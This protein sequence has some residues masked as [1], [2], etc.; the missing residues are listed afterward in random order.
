MNSAG[1]GLARSLL[2][3]ERES[4]VRAG[5]ALRSNADSSKTRLPLPAGRKPG[6]LG[7][8]RA[9]FRNLTFGECLSAHLK[10]CMTER[11]PS[12][13]KTLDDVAS[14]AERRSFVTAAKRLGELRM[15]QER[16]MDMEEKTLFPIIERLGGATEALAEG[17]AEHAAIRRLL[18][19]VSDALS[20]RAL[21]QFMDAHR[22][23][24][25][26]LS[27]HWQNEER[28]LGSELKVPNE[29]TF[30]E[31]ASALRRC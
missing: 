5:W 12:L 29:E 14:L 8:E 21:Q 16:H 17:K 28:L 15:E 3:R 6:E 4:G 20:A 22:Q 31:I 30:E 1:H 26:A 2:D 27:E 25:T 11:H 7:P 10:R 9:R 13:K 24:L 23:L 18:D 19:A